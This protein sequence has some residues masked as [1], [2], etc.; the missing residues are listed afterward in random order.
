VIALR[1][2]DDP[3][4]VAAI[5]LND[6]HLGDQILLHEVTLAECLVGPALIG[7]L[8]AANR[9]AREAFDIVSTDAGAPKRWAELRAACR[10]RLPD[11]I[12]LDVAIRF[13]ATTI[14]TFD[15][16]LIAEAARRRS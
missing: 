13:A 1:D 6:A 10:L 4:H 5:A 9:S 11:V 12:V 16:R 3:H 8:D 14:L 7:R 15:S 2:A